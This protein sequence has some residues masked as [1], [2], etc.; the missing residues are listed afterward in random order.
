MQNQT[1]QIVRKSNKGIVEKPDI[2]ELFIVWLVTP[3]LEKKKM[4]LESQKAFADRYG[5]SERTLLRWKGM[6][7]LRARVKD[8]REKL[9]FERTQGVIDGM[10]KSA[11]MGNDRS[12]KLWFQIFEGF[13][14][15]QE[16]KQTLK[17]ELT[18]ND[19]RYL[20]DGLPEPYRSEH[21]GNLTKLLK[22]ATMVE[23]A[24]NVEISNLTDGA[25]GEI[26]TETYNDAQSVPGNG[27][28]VVA[29]GYQECVCEDMEWPLPENNYQG[30]SRRW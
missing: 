30:A 7:E 2:Y 17:V 14:E 26:Y 16:V 10:Y 8:I 23:K 6:P 29:K 21:Y 11:V 18:V 4:E 19:I 20:I 3:I 28:N 12:Q 9:A 22:D 15:K 13:T 1:T 24:R 25:E 5:V 27:N